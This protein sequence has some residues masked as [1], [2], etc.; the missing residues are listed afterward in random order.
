MT[1][2]TEKIT[3][4]TKKAAMFLGDNRKCWGKSSYEFRIFHLAV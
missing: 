1:S 3:Y 2:V 4:K